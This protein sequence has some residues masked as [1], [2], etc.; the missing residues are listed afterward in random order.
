MGKPRRCSGAF[1]E[2]ERATLNVRRQKIRHLQQNKVADLK[3]Y[4]DLPES[5]PH[6]LVVGTNVA[7]LARVFDGLYFGVVEGI[8]STNG[9]YRVAFNRPD[10]GCHSIPDFEVASMTTPVMA[11]LASFEMKPRK[12]WQLINKFVE[13]SPE[14]G[15]GQQSH[16]NLQSKAHLSGDRQLQRTLS[17]TSTSAVVQQQQRQQTQQQQ[18]Q[19]TSDSNANLDGAIGG[20]PIRFLLQL[21]KASGTLTRKR[22]AV[23]ELRETNTAIERMTT[24][25]EPISYSFKKSYALSILELSRLNK[26]VARYLGAM[27]S[28]SLQMAGEGRRLKSLK[29]DVVSQKCLVESKALVE[30]LQATKSVRLGSSGT[31]SLIVHLMSLLFHLRAFRDSEVS[32]YELQSLTETIAAIRKQ[33][34]AGNV[35]AFTS[36]VEIHIRHIMSSVS[37]LGNV[38]AFSE[39]VTSNG[40]NGS[41]GNGSNGSGS[42]FSTE[43]KEIKSEV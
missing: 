21:V 23:A 17:S 41:N 26:D 27:Q 7:A 40:S 20:F 15:S 43:T 18:N 8:D 13:S 38:G 39:S 14:G 36:N 3:A 12:P 29:P 30:R 42:T 22:K 31:A 25:S 5:I 34:A 16:S 1:F 28:Y 6:P 35:E 9:T 10:V 4:K 24:Y 11:P 32:C 33:I 2:E 37:H 19:T